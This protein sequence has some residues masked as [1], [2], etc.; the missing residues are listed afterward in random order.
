MISVGK[1][2]FLLLPD[3]TLYRALTSENKVLRLPL[4]AE[5]IF[6]AMVRASFQPLCDPGSEGSQHSPGKSV[7]VRTSLAGKSSSRGQSHWKSLPSILY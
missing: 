3:E 6:G 1:P 7:V 2:G 5:T 4:L